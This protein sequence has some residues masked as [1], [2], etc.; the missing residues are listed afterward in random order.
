MSRIKSLRL[1]V[2]TIERLSKAAIKAGKTESA[3]IAELLMDRLLVDPLVP[4]VQEILLST[5]TLLLILASVNVDALEVAAAD[6]ANADVPLAREL[7]ESQG[8][9]LDFV[10]LVTEIMGKHRRWFHVEMSRSSVTESMVLH[11]THG[12]MWSRFIGG[13]LLTSHDI[14]SPSTVQPHLKVDKLF[15]RIDKGKS[16]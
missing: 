14:L 6:A 16:R 13:Y 1:E 4:V 11:H 9:S 7:Y 15:V 5:S 8:R 10:T 2:D 3:L 12:L